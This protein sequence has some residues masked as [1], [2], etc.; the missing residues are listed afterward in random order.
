[1]IGAST[2]ASFAWGTAVIGADT[3]AAPS[4]WLYKQAVQLT[5]GVL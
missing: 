3:L 4:F 5:F 2:S 1:M